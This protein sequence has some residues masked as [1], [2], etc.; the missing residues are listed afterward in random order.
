[1][2]LARRHFRGAGC[3]EDASAS[4]TLRSVCHGLRQWV[5][6][7]VALRPKRYAPWVTAL[8]VLASLY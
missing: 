6:G 5:I 3:F 7:A 4:N 1:M 2:R 8:P